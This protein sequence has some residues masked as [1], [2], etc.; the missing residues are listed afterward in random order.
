MLNL[1]CPSIWNKLHTKHDYISV[2]YN[3]LTL[4]DVQHNVVGSATIDWASTGLRKQLVQ[5]SSGS[6]KDSPAPA[7][8]SLDL[9]TP[10][11]GSPRQSL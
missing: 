10:L 8:W 9:V 6:M 5:D 2:Y 3:T 11:T 1:E 7:Q 4:L